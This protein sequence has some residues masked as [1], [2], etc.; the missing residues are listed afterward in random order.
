MSG[1]S[2]QRTKIFEE[3][4]HLDGM[5]ARCGRSQLFSEEVYDGSRTA[6]DGSFIPGE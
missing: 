1:D 2:L 6:F 4:R 3:C 5:P